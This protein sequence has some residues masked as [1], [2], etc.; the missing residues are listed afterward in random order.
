L[1]A[2]SLDGTQ[3]WALDAMTGQ[4][5]ATLSVPAATSITRVR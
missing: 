1:Y 5:I 3:L 2:L 4:P